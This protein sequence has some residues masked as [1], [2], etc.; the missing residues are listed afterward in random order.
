MTLPQGS[1]NMCKCEEI[2]EL[3]PSSHNTSDSSSNSDD[4]N[5]LSSYPNALRLRFAPNAK[6]IYIAAGNYE[7]IMKWKDILSLYCKRSVHKI[8]SSPLKSMKMNNKKLT[9]PT[10]NNPID[11]NDFEAIDNIDEIDEDNELENLNVKA[12]EEYDNEFNNDEH[13]NEFVYDDK[14]LTSMRIKKSSLNNGK[15]EFYYKYQNNVANCQSLS[16]SSSSSSSS[17]ANR[18]RSETLKLKM[19]SGIKKSKLTFDF[20]S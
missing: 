18:N 7:E 14:E 12:D 9:S 13:G 17:T 20:F 11:L 2:I 8:E 15:G 19:V 3:N 16:S 4:T 5:S 6:D 10:M 1:I